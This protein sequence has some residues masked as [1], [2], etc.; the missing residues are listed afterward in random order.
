MGWYDAL[1]NRG[2]I[3]AVTH[4]GPIAVLRGTLGQFPI[5]KWFALAPN[6]GEIV[7]LE[8]T[9]PSD[10]LPRRVAGG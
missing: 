9:P 1:P 10:D 3:V 5:N 2:L 6:H 4:G 7:E 8:T